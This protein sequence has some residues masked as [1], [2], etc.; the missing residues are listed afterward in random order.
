MAINQLT[1]VPGFGHLSSLMASDVDQTLM[2][3]KR[4]DKLAN[5]DLLYYQSELCEL[6]A[7]QEQYDREDAEDADN[8]TAGKGD[9]IRENARDWAA[10]RTSAKKTNANAHN[11]RWKLRMQH[12][13]RIRKTLKE[14]RRYCYIEFVNSSSN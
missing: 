4:F 11:A 14:Y 6:Q 13:M 8:V 1:Y 7:L 5:R 3:Y 2:V 10:F 9:D 12:A